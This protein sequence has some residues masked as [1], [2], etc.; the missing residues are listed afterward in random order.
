MTYET[1]V[2]IGGPMLVRA[3]KKDT[4]LFPLGLSWEEK[5]TKNG[6]VMEAPCVAEQLEEHGLTLHWTHDR[7]RMAKIHTEHGWQQVGVGKEDEYYAIV[8]R[9]MK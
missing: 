1:V 6:P 9:R 7:W 2:A 8:L 3:D 5:R 4:H